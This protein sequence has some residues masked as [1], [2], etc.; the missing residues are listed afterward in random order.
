[1][2]WAV[3]YLDKPW[4]RTVDTHPLKRKHFMELLELRAVF[5]RFHPSSFVF[6][7]FKQFSNVF[8]CFQPFC[9]GP[10]ICNRRGIQSLKYAFFNQWLDLGELEKP[11]IRE[12]YCIRDASQGC[13]RD[14]RVF[15]IYND[16]LVI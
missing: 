4:C 7:R 3:R 9:I 10:N 6:N 5:N 8:N 12:W 13:L 11:G 14:L 1:M 16:F 2:S 15:K